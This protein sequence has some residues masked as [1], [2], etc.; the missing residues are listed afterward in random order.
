MEIKNLLGGDNQTERSLGMSFVR[1]GKGFSFF[2]N[3]FLDP[4][5]LKQK[6]ISSSLYL[7]EE[8]LRRG[9]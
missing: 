7:G 2:N 3:S 1:V 9:N 5:I 4:G 6:I 8:E